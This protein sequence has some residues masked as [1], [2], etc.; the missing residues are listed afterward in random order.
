MENKSV[1]FI[2]AKYIDFVY[3]TSKVTFSGEDKIWGSEKQEAYLA[4]F[5][6][7][8]SYSLYPA[9]KGK[10]LDVITTVNKRGDYIEKMCHYFDYEVLRV[11]DESDG[12][13]QLSWLSKKIIENEDHYIAL[14]MDGPL[15][16][17]HEPKDLAF[18]LAL[19]TKRK[20]L[21]V[22]IEISR[23]IVVSKRWD[24]FKIPLPFNKIVVHF[25]EP[26]IVTREDRK[27]HFSILKSD[28]KE[29]M[30]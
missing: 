29:M 21:P 4:L 22:S 9:F 5:W 13:K 14:A 1:A 28:I 24:N 7:G 18:V 23:S 6:H 8:N 16:P 11:P 10:K 27:D 15:G 26:M 20:I 19:L 30:H 25:K 3:H 2:L 17:Y 12:G